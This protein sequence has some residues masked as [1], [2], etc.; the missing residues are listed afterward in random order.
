[1]EITHPFH[2]LKGHRFRPLR[3]WRH[4]GRQFLILEKA[5]SDTFAILESWTSEDPGPIDGE[6][7]LSPDVVLDLLG[8]LDAMMA[9]P[10]EGLDKGAAGC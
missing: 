1:M 4:S 3:R 6:E 7:R 2:P 9:D 10:R 5:P 8:V